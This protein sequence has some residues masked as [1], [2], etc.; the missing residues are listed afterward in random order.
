MKVSFDY[1]GTLQLAKIQKLAKS[2]IDSGNDVW[3]I[4]TRTNQYGCHNNEDMFFV[5]GMVGIPLNKIIFTH[6]SYK[7][8]AFIKNGFDLH[9]DDEWKEI[10]TINKAGGLAI[11]VTSDMSDVFI[12]MQSRF[13]EKV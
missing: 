8:N 11:L 5:C 2:L 13:N 12:E 9:F 1:D 4:T 10:E 6:G 7:F 3:I